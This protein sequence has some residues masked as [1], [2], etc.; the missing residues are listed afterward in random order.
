MDHLWLVIK[1][2]IDAAGSPKASADWK[3][4]LPNITESHPDFDP[5]PE[6]FGAYWN[7]NVRTTLAK[8]KRQ[9]LAEAAGKRGTPDELA[10]HGVTIIAD[11]RDARGRKSTKRPKGKGK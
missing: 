3:T 4:L 10:Q 5:D 11:A 1:Y 8:K 9:Q 2:V 6:A 7:A